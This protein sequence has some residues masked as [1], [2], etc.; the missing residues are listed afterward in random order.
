MYEGGAPSAARTATGRAVVPLHR[1]ACTFSDLPVPHVP[2]ALSKTTTRLDERTMHTQSRSS[3]HWPRPAQTPEALSSRGRFALNQFTLDHQRLQHTR[4][5]A[6]GQGALLRGSN[7]T[8]HVAQAT[9]R[10]AKNASERGRQ[11]TQETLLQPEEWL[12]RAVFRPLLSIEASLPVV[13]DE[14]S[15]CHRPM[16]CVMTRHETGLT[17]LPIFSVQPNNFRVFT[18]SRNQGVALGGPRAR[19]QG[20][21]RALRV[22]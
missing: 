22:H 20:K 12:E 4:A 1:H 14:H 13:V 15:L 19:P 10:R 8:E 7:T 6:P 11:G 16:A 17:K 21:I 2:R 18:A 5:A 9:R 3:C